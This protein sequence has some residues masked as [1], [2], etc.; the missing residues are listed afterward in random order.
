MADFSSE[1]YFDDF[2]EDNQF[3]KVLF[4][5]GYAVQ[6]RELNQIQSILQNQ[7]NSVGK[8]LFKEG[9]VVIPGSVLY[10]N[11]M[12]YVKLQPTNTAGNDITSIISSL[13]KTTITGATSGAKAVVIHAELSDGVDPAILYVR[14]ISSGTSTTYFSDGE[15]LS[16]DDLLPIEVLAATTSSTGYGTI[17]SINDGIYFA[18]GYFIRVYATNLVLS[19]FGNTPTNKV[20]IL[21]SENIITPE[22]NELLLDNATGSPNYAAPGAHR[23]NISTEFVKIGI[24][25]SPDNFIELINV[26]NGYAS[27]IQDSPKYNEIEKELARRTYDES[28]NYVVNNFNINLR[29]H[30]K[31][32]FSSRQNSTSYKLGD[33]IVV[34]ISSIDYRYKCVQAGLS[35][36]I[37]PTYTTTFSSPFL[38]GTVKWEYIESV[39]IND[40]LDSTGDDSKYVIE[41][42][43]GT[44]YIKGF[45]YS[46]QGVLR[47]I[48]DK[49]RDFD[50]TNNASIT[51]YDGTYI[52]A[53][54]VYSIPST[55]GTDFVTIDLYNRYTEV[56]GSPSGTKIGTASLRWVERDSGSNNF[57]LYVYDIS[58]SSGYTFEKHCKQV[59]FNNT[60]GNDF[61]CDIVP[62]HNILTGSIT[63]AGTA[64]TG[65]GT[66]FATEV[67]IGDYITVDQINY[68]RVAT[69]A[70]NN[71]LT[72]ATSLTTTGSIVYRTSSTQFNTT[73]NS[74]VVGL[75]NKFIRKIKG[76]DDSTV[77]TQYTITRSLGVITSNGSGRVD[78][79]ISSPEA[80]APTSNGSSYLFINNTTGAAQIPSSYTVN[81][82]TSIYANGL[83]AATG[84]TVFAT[85]TKTAIQRTKTLN[86]ATIDLTTSS[87]ATT[88]VIS[89]GK[90]DCYKILAI[91]QA[92]AFGTI[93]SSNPANIDITNLFKFD[94]GQTNLMYG[95]GYITRTNE[96]L[97]ITGSIR[98]SFEYFTHSS[99][100][101]FSIDSYE[102]VIPYTDIEPKLR[103]TLDFRPVKNDSGIGFNSSP[104]GILKSGYN[105]SADYS[106]YLPRVDA[107]VLN[108]DKT[109]SL[110]NGISK[111]KPIAPNIPDDCM[112]LYYIA[113]YPYGG[114]P[115]KS[116]AIKSVDNRRYTM[117]DISALDKRLSN[118]EYY[119]SLSLL[120]QQTS[121]L[122]IT[123]S[124]GLDMYKNGF[125]IESFNDHGIGDVSN[126]DY[127][128]FINS[129]SSELYPPHNQQSILLTE[130]NILDSE[131]TADNY[132]INDGIITLPYEEVEYMSNNY[133]SRVENVN[134]FSIATFNGNLSVV[135][136]SDVW[137]D[138]VTLP[139]I[140]QTA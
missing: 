59:Y 43:G 13:E 117:R 83:T 78:M 73:Y 92:S 103:D 32:F 124:D 119:V 123:D 120:E 15:S 135:P 60:S 109:I 3:Y 61:T 134:P 37:P 137:Y 140:K 113:N 96:Q 7:V 34:S 14:Y 98:I 74:A 82:S 72:L 111:L 41:L 81:S 93:N 53:K 36:S 48:N 105:I 52:L 47:L 66:L 133:A 127:R 2:S 63:A 12:P 58:V 138:T 51:V 35:G 67:S 70:N 90:A 17:A 91:K 132:V 131:R 57:R 64:V 33:V 128:C 99:G 19:K 107:I 20:G 85:I 104:L 4:R 11:R 108:K 84:Y 97:K 114:H 55:L 65:T 29:E 68:F 77:D 39:Y 121:N 118:L 21:W 125:I 10:D 26:E 18:N 115:S 112:P 9:S 42:N 88:N 46:K 44:A 22:D 27:I 8:H 69:V 30:R 40:G 49:A 76:T 45:E 95:L 1:P 116:V 5:P 71:S 62:V 87:T 6:T 50:R 38:D 31:N 129:S 94:S 56:N 139:T 122:S 89:L 79:T 100:D 25:D 86:V 75:P 23:Y 24:T 28:G 80:F 130:I 102:N 136:S 110:L 101:Y 54:N 126:V 16:N 106:Y